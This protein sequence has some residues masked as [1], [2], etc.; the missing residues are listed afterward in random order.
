MPL[1][2]LSTLGFEMPEILTKL[3]ESSHI[4]KA[5]VLKQVFQHNQFFF[6]RGSRG[7][8]RSVIWSTLGESFVYTL[9]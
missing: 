1:D 3:S 7:P 5:S 2:Q 8:W 6:F 4:F 9:S